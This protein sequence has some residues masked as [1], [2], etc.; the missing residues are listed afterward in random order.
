MKGRGTWPTIGLI[1]L[2]AISLWRFMG[3]PAYGAQLGQRAVQVNN[4]QVSALTEY[5]LS[6][7]LTTPGTLGSILIQF[8]AN[9]PL[10]G[11]PCVAPPGFTTGSAILTDQTG[12][13]GFVIDS[14]STANEV[15]LSRTPALASAGPTSFHFTDVTNPSTTGT[16]YIR[17]LTYA[18]DD[19]SGTA[20][21]YGGIAVSINEDL[22]I[23]ATVPPY[24]I[25]CTANTINGLNCNDINGDF[26]DFGELST[27][28]AR[29]GSSQ[30]LVATNAE[31][32]YSITM[33]G[34][35]LTSGTNII[36]AIGGPD[37]SRPGTSQFGM[38][39]RANSAPA[40]GSD[41]LGPGAGTPTANYNQPNF[42]RFAT[43]DIIASHTLGDRR[44]YT[45]SYITNIGNTQPAG[46]YVSTITYVCLA[47]F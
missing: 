31:N 21:D 24:L 43:G 1:L 7:E 19:A 26:I 9:D 27:T 6:F 37:V 11:Q 12:P 40:V 18:T 38:N 10:P 4:G 30:M 13:G 47:N 46:I 35:T 14:A 32:G 8:C 29:R 16:F 42:F 2:L 44:K 5:I 39:L 25:F 3:T 15:I 33:S 23:S 36:N 34:T 20:S 17:V 22:S 45:A 41:P 28:Q